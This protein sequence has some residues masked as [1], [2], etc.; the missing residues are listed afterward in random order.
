MF[1]RANAL[2]ELQQARGAADKKEIEEAVR[3]RREEAVRVEALERE[4]E[5]R[6]SRS[7]RAVYLLDLVGVG[8]SQRR[9]LDGKTK[10]VELAGCLT[11]CPGAL[12]LTCPQT[13]AGWLAASKSLLRPNTNPVKQPEH[14][15]PQL[16]LVRLT[17]DFLLRLARTRQC[18][19]GRQR[20]ITCVSQ[21]E[22]H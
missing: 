19:M 7:R 9:I 21:Q 12:H 10:P 16:I 8:E 3:R 20:A 14:Q 11:G 1:G 17:K 15:Q 18:E 22:A 5:E 2:R 6:R 4:R 13:L